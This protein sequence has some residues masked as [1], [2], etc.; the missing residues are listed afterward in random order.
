M[1]RNTLM[2]AIGV[3]SVALLV[4]GALGA[5]RL[6]SY[7]G[8]LFILAVI[9]VP[10][11]EAGDTERSLAP[12]TGLVGGLAVLFFVGLTGIWLLWSPDI[13]TYSYVLGLPEA[14]LVYFLFLW[15]LP[16]LGAIYYSLTFD[17][18]GS[19]EIVKGI[20]SEART[21]QE[22]EALPLAPDQVER[23]TDLEVE[24]TDD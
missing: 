18:I 15:V 2:T 16:L 3:V 4:T 17:R 19:E 20:L 6:F 11:I 9:A 10:S 24:A 7:L 5:Y 1:A 14:T 23:T 21:A 12:F 22:R 13:T 8:A